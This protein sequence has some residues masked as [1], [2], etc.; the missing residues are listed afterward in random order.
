M[1]HVEVPPSLL[2][3]LVLLEL[4]HA[5]LLGVGGFYIVLVVHLLMFA[6]VVIHFHRDILVLLEWYLVAPVLL[7]TW[8]RINAL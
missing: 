7:M 5:L 3:V 6:I 2:N 4:K 1:A 8:P